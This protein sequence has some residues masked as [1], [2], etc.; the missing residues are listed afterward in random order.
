MLALSKS[1]QDWWCWC[2]EFAEEVPRS[3]LMSRA[4]G[5]LPLTFRTTD[6]AH[7]CCMCKAD[8]ICVRS[9]LNAVEST[10]AG[11]GSAE[12]VSDSLGA[13][14]SS[15]NRAEPQ[16]V[17]AGTGTRGL[18]SDTV[19]PEAWRRVLGDSVHSW[20]V[21]TAGIWLNPHVSRAAVLLLLGWEARR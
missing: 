3:L 18:A 17:P 4:A 20:H 1:A 16:G 14:H 12:G 9:V 7:T 11:L 21:G 5:V 2:A 8:G 19:C 15:R 13:L 6:Q 10:G